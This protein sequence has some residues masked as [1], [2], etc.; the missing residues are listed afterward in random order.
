MASRRRPGGGRRSHAPRWTLLLLILASIT[1]ITLSYRGDL[2]GTISG[3][4]RAAHDAI[5]PAQDAVDDV[6]R[7]VAGFVAGAFHYEAVQTQNDKL[8]RQLETLQNEQA[9]DGDVRRR[10]ALLGQLEHLPWAEVSSIPTVTAQ[11]DALN[12]SNFADTVQ[13]DEG[14]GAGVAVGMPVVAGQGLV[15]RVTDAWSSGC[16]V[17]LVTDANSAVSV[18][19]GSTTV[20]AVVSGRGQDSALAVDY[21]TPG[22]AVS[23]GEVLTTSGYQGDLF[24]PGIP[25]AKVSSVSS[26]ASSTAE[27][28]SARPLSDLDSLQYVDVLIWEPPITPTGAGS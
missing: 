22:T 7:P 5:A 10:L 24:P 23:T 4:K 14:T 12:S 20:Q 26:S 6:L 11:V 28:I 13:L 25:V 9:A 17:T 15:G 3:A 21:V 8:R 18:V 16:T 1:V 19:L 27:T 2:R